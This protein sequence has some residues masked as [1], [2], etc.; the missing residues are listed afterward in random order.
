MTVTGKNVRSHNS[1]TFDAASDRG[2]NDCRVPVSAHFIFFKDRQIRRDFEY[3]EV[4]L[5]LICDR[6]AQKFGVDLETLERVAEEKGE[7]N[8]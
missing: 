7:Q 3:G 1:R 8:T 4:P 5:E 6:I 2:D